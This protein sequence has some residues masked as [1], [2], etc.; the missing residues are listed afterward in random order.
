MKNVF[1]VLVKARKDDKFV[2]WD[3]LMASCCTENISCNMLEILERNG[4][5]TVNRRSIKKVILT[6][7]GYRY[8]LEYI[9]KEGN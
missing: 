4:I 8:A 6:S 3:M 5:I 2:D 7:A 9:A 1:T